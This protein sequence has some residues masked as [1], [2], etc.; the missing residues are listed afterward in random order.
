MT[1]KF[2]II[3]MNANPEQKGDLE[4]NNW[5]YSIYGI[6]CRPTYPCLPNYCSPDLYPCDPYCGPSKGDPCYPEEGCY[7]GPCDPKV[8]GLG[9]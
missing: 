4:S 6:T 3:E 5:E 8:G 9:Y 2:E 7:P 1:G